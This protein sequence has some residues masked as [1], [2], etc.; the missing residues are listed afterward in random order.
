MV[1]VFFK[2]HEKG[3]IHGIG[4]AED[5]LPTVV[6]RRS[7]NQCT[8][9]PFLVDGIFEKNENKTLVLRTAFDD[10]LSPRLTPW[11]WVFT[12]VMKYQEMHP[13]KQWNLYGL[14]LSE[15]AKYRNLPNAFIDE[16]T[17]EPT[18]GDGNSNSD[19]NSIYV[20]IEPLQ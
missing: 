13:L 5:L 15:Q 3:I 9:T 6:R 10:I 11:N 2:Q 14:H 17:Q 18:Q 16:S 12:A 8:P 19:I 4:C 1:Q 7:F 20:P